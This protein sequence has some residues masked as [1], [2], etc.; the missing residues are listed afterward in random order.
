MMAL[1]YLEG[2]ELSTFHQ[3]P[4]L[5]AAN[6]DKSA[7]HVRRRMRVLAAAGLITRTNEQAGYYAIT[8]LG[9]RYLSS[10]LTDDEIIRLQE[11]DPDT[12]QDS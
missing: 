8:D 2:H 11:F 9:R 12:Q 6:L 4:A 7:G 10:E 5:I 1:E 3:S